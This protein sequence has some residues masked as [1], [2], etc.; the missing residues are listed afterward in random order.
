M[1]FMPV[2]LWYLVFVAA[3]LLGAGTATITICAANFQV[4][5]SQVLII[6]ADL[7]GTKFESG[8]FVYGAHRF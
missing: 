1:F 4:K 3:V 8:A 6:K 7:I 5:D 2:K